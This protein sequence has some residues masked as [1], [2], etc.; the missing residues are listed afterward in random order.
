MVS[1]STRIDSIGLI[2][3]LIDHRKF[4][5]RFESKRLRVCAA[6]LVVVC[7]I[8][9]GSQRLRRRAN[10]DRRRLCVLE[11]EL[12]FGALIL[13][14]MQAK[15]HTHAHKYIHLKVSIASHSSS[16]TLH[17]TTTQGVCVCYSV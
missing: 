14:W 11:H 2:E 12:G 5:N 13:C 17:A 16:V 4:N 6:V 3:I 10:N 7:T 15:Q 1:K 8:F 9:S